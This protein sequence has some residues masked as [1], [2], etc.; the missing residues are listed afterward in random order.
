MGAA[1]EGATGAGLLVAV[2]D[3]S[4]LDTFKEASSLAK[5]V[6]G[7]RGPTTASSSVTSRRSVPGFGVIASPSEVEAD[8][9]VVAVGPSRPSAAKA[10]DELDAYRVFVLQLA[11]AVGKAAGGGDQAEAGATGEDQG[12]SRLA[13]RAGVVRARLPLGLRIRPH[14]LRDP[15]DVVEVRDHL[16]RVVDRRVV[17][18]LRAERLGVVG[19]DRGRCRASASARSRRAHGCVGRA[20]PRGSRARHVMPARLVRPRHGG[21]R[22]GIGVSSSTRSSPRRRWR[23]APRS[24]RVSPDGPSM[25]AL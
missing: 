23:A 9:G 16:D 15:V 22:R 12:G 4:F 3:R 1:T 21:R 24:C 5:Y 13:A 7:A 11:E 8:D 6:A 14:A 10:P 2:S 20:P 18:A 17:D 19:P 25:I